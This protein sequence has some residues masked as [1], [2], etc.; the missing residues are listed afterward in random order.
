MSKGFDTQPARGESEKSDFIQWTDSL[1]VTPRDG[2]WSNNLRQITNHIASRKLTS[3]K[4]ISHFY[5]TAVGSRLHPHKSW[6]PCL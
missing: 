1:T 4:C 2:L 6:L 5:T 3:R